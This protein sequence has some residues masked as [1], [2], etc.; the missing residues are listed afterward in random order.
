[1]A[2]TPSNWS[3]CITAVETAAGRE[4]SENDLEEIFTRIQARS[5]R[6]QADGMSLND[7][8]VRAAQDLGDQMRVAAAID[9]RV[10]LNDIVIDRQL[11][12]RISEGSAYKDIQTI[13]DGKE[14][15]KLNDAFSV[16]S[17]IKAEIA[18]VFGP[19]VNDLTRTGLRKVLQRGDADFDRAVIKELWALAEDGKAVTGNKL[20]RQAADIIN[21]S[22]ENVRLAQNAVGAWIGKRDQYVAKQS[23]DRD[24]LRKAG[25]QAWIDYIQ[26]RLDVRTFDTLDEVTPANVQEYL[27]TTY[28][29]LSS[30]VHDVARGTA[31][32]GDV[33]AGTSSGNLAK[34]VSQERKLIFKDGDAWADY[35]STFGRGTLYE[36]VTQGLD[37]GAR[38]TAIMRNLGTNP[39]AMLDKKIEQYRVLASKRI[40]HVESDKLTSKFLKDILNVV[41][42]KANNPENMTLANITSN[43]AALQTLSKLGGV[44][45]SSLPD[46]AVTTATLRH[47]GVGIFE[48][49]F[50]Q[51]R[52]LLP[53][54]DETKEVARLT[55]IGID[56]MLKSNAAHLMS[57]DN[58][59]GKASQLVDIF[60]K[61]NGL[62]YWT[63]SMKEGVGLILMSNLA[64]LSDTAHEALNPRLQTTLR[65]YGIEGGEWDHARASGKRNADGTDYLMPSEI[66]DANVRVRFQAYLADQIRES[67]TEPDAY[68]KAVGTWGTQSGTV[69]GSAVRILMQFKTYPITFMST[70]LNREFRRDGV[71]VMGLT[72]LIVGTSLMGYVALELKNLAQGKDTRRSSAQ[73]AGD[74]AKLV[75]AAM[76]QG[77]GMG[78]YGDFLFGDSSRMG[79]GPVMSLFGPTAGTADNVI[80]EIQ[81]LRKWITEGDPRAGLDARS[82]ALGLVRDNTPFVNMFYARGILNYMLW[83]RLQEAS[84]PGYLRRYE[85]RVRREQAQTF[86][87]SPATGEARAPRL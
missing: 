86:F 46:L 21:R 73:D 34:R 52:S 60:H 37:N 48:G 58:I 61:L 81:Q 27:L 72:H 39:E 56:G 23:H 62:E 8:S 66:E 51:I 24:K 45:L 44:V 63:T 7:A 14:G 31:E 6:Y 78:L 33:G 77:G 32:W 67:I 17:Q 64:R 9:H 80:Q 2:R 11:D 83:Y 74:Y 69:A 12:T 53:R 49:Y 75:A 1:M 15:N 59:R 13:L 5:R 50:N 22:L 38:N 4:F 70:T 47:N 87:I 41:T 43:A 82:G 16:N 25:A 26:D 20:A 19:F 35:N 3:H 71:D 68:A 65:R 57:R 18:H 40:D 54:G 36:A 84:N 42:G 76:V 79:N 29:A 10:K 30:G 28:K 85:E 55:S